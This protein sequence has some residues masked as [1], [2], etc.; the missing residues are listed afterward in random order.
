VHLRPSRRLRAAHSSMSI[1]LCP[2][3]KSLISQ[4]IGRARRWACSPHR[5]HFCRATATLT[6]K[7]WSLSSRGRALS[8]SSRPLR[9]H[10]CDWGERGFLVFLLSPWLRRASACGTLLKGPPIG[11]HSDTAMLTFA[12]LAFQPKGPI[13]RSRAGT[14]HV[15]AKG[16]WDSPNRAP[17]VSGRAFEPAEP[18]SR[19]TGSR[20]LYPVDREILLSPK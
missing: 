11:R 4:M 15:G 9:S 3:R 12:Q 6:G 7:S 19:S 10:C 2:C 18:V 1:R 17:R 13:R 14:A 16:A 5:G 8:L 20:P